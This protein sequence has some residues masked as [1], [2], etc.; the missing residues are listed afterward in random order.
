MIK[1]CIII[2]DLMKHYTKTCFRCII[3]STD[4]TFKCDIIM[5]GGLTK[6]LAVSWLQVDVTTNFS[7]NTKCKEPSSLMD[8][9]VQHK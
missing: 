1:I 6:L 7:R 9:P 4:C 2:A 5:G 3:P 8:K